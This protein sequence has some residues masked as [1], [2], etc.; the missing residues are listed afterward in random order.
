[1]NTADLLKFRSDKDHFFKR[2][3][4]SPL[5]HEAQHNF[6]GLA[7]FEPN[8]DL[9]F[10]VSLDA[11]EPSDVTIATTAGEERTYS[12]VATATVS[13][14]GED[15][16]VALYSTGHEGLFLPF[17]DA[18]S[19]SETYGAGRYIDVHPQGDGTV[20]IDFNYAYAPFCAY[21][22][23]YSCALPPHENWLSVA[24]RAG[25]RNPA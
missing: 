12:R 21:N 11:V 10:E 4:Q 1:M 14:D 24:I 17:R 20:V 19:G 18:T 9:V 6:D 22:E 7:Y 16:T 3:E 8:D 5:T 13:V 23:N 25:E 2:S 15:T